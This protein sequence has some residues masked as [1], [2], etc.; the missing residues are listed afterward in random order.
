MADLVTTVAADH[1]PL[2]LSA[3]CAA[4]ENAPELELVGSAVDGEDALAKARALRPAVLVLEAV[5]PGPGPTEIAA[6]LAAQGSPTRVLC[7]AAIVDGDAIRQSLAGGVAGYLSKDAHGEVV[8]RAVADVAAGVVVIEPG[9]NAAFV[10]ALRRDTEIVVTLTARELDVLR[11]TA[12]GHNAAEIGA[13]L[14]VSWTTVRTHLGKVY[15]K[16]EA[17]SQAQAVAKALRLGLID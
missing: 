14:D 6:A 9:L 12:D 17:R 5:M 2:F 3:L 13:L 1:H 11:L 8:L 7:L 15:N 4:I 16:L 10:D